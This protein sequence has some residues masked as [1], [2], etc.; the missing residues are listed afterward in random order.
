MEP[1]AR[2]AFAEAGRGHSQVPQMQRDLGHPLSFWTQVRALPARP[3]RACA[4]YD[5]RGLSARRGASG[6]PASRS[7]IDPSGTENYPR[8]RSGLHV[9]LLGR[10]HGGNGAAVKLQLCEVKDV[11]LSGG[12]AGARDR[13]SVCS[14]DAVERNAPGTC[15]VIGLFSRIGTASSRTVPRSAGALLRMTSSKNHIVNRKHWESPR[16]RPGPIL[17]RWAS[18]LRCRR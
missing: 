14:L 1:A 9:I 6:L 8:K 7:A 5:R 16:C 15:S 2:S 12:A 10:M 4:Q 18:G 13:T 3:S 17:W 11:I